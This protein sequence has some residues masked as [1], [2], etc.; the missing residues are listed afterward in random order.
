[1]ILGFYQAASLAPGGLGLPTDLLDRQTLNK[2]ELALYIQIWDRAEK[3][4]E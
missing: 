1:M 3:T 4:K 2:D